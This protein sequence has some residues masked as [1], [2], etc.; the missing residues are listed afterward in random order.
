MLLSKTVSNTP[1]TVLEYYA[2]FEMSGFYFINLPWK[3]MKSSF[4]RS[5]QIKDIKILVNLS[6]LFAHDTNKKTNKL[7]DD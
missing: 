2:L 6:T 1:E 3:R 5:P 4:I 7:M